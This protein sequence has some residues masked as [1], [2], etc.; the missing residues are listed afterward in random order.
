MFNKANTVATKKPA[1]AKS[2]KREIEMQGI[3]SLAA[4]DSVIKSLLA[5]K[6]TIEEGI[7]AEAMEIF[8]RDGAALHAQPENFR[9]IE[10]AGEA[11]VELRKRST[12]SELTEEELTMLARFNVPTTEVVSV[13]ETYVINP[14]Y[15]NDSK[16]LEK[17]ANA[18][19]GVKGLPEDLFLFQEGKSKK[20][21]AENS[22]A[23]VFAL[24]QAEIAHVLPL[25]S[26]QALKPKMVAADPNE[27]F[28]LVGNLI[29]MDVAPKKVAKK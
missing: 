6:G 21:V 7:K 24:K 23:A 14:E 5:L 28:R 17:V 2:K 22:M 1:S 20:V 26:T 16:L 3:E 10:G 11:S 13:V 9:G 19:K 15:G 8:V 25:V 12:A 29:G 18:L 4:V 27:A